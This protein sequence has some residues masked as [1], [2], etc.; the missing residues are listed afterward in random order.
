M[1][2]ASV[3]TV[4]PVNPI[5]NEINKIIQPQNKIV[6][7]LQAQMKCGSV[8]DPREAYSRMHNRHNRS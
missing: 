2:E 8:I 6:E 4:S 7:R 3:K 1:K 5:S